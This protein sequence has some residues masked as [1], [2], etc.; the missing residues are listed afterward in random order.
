MYWYVGRSTSFPAPFSSA[1]LDDKRD[2]GNRAWER[3]FWNFPEHLKC[4][5]C[6]TT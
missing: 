4:V 5:I 2:K 6:L 3:G 1:Y